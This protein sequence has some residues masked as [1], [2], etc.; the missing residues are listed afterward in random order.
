MFIDAKKQL[1]LTVGS[2]FRAESLRFNTN[3][4]LQI[5]HKTGYSLSSK[6]THMQKIHVFWDVTQRRLVNGSRRFY[7]S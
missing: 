6:G 2:F 7:G 3:Y 4:Y 1:Q 5:S